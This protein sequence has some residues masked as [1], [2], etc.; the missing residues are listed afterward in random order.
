MPS[1]MALMKLTHRHPPFRVH[2]PPHRM[3]DVVYNTSS[4]PALLRT[5]TS[6]LALSN[7]A[8]SNHGGDDSDGVQDA[9]GDAGDDHDP[10]SGSSRA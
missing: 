5:L 4:F 10:G 9:N 3:A 6:L 8:E 1:Y 2:V 7:N